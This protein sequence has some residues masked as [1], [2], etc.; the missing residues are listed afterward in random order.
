MERS[1]EI[2]TIVLGIYDTRRAI[3]PIGLVLDDPDVHGIGS[4][5]AE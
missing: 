2:R 3:R 5:P 4:D 1:P